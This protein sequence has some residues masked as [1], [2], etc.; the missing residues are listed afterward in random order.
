MA[1]MN[2]EEI[3]KILESKKA[4]LPCPSCGNDAFTLLDGFFTQEFMGWGSIF[5]TAGG[6]RSI[7]YIA[8]V[9]DNCG[10]VRH[11][12]IKPLGITPKPRV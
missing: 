12:A 10:F 4:I 11:H 6:P 8:L 3:I 1:P 7:T 5:T 9:C 2:S